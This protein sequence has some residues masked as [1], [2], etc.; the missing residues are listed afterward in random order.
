MFCFQLLKYEYFLV[1]LVLYDSKLNIFGL[2]TV[3]WEKNKTFKNIT[4]SCGKL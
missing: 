3:G 1:S 2:W 4:L